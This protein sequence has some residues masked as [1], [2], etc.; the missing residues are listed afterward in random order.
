MPVFKSIGPFVT[1]EDM[2]IVD[3]VTVDGT[4]TGTPVDVT[5]WA[6]IFTLWTRKEDAAATYSVALSTGGANGQLTAL[7]PNATSSTLS[8]RAYW[9]QFTRTDTGFNATLSEGTITFCS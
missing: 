1:G 3:T 2:T 8:D 9:F 4:A 7:I 6:G 5:G